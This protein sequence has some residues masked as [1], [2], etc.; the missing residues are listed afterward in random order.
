VQGKLLSLS[1]TLHCGV[2]WNE[3]NL[4]DFCF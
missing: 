2:E 4:F 1:T 3:M